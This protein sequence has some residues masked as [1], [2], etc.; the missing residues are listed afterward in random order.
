MLESVLGVRLLL[1]TGNPVPTP[2]PSLIEPL[3]TVEVRNDTESGDGF[4]MT[5]A[6]TKD[7]F[8]RYDVVD[9]LSPGTRV[10]IGAVIGVVPEPLIDGVV[11]RHD[12][13]PSDRPGETTLTVT[14]RTVTSLLGLEE[15][16]TSFANQPDYVIVTRTLASYPELGFVPDVTPTTDVPIELQRT[17]QQ[18]E[19]DLA[20]INRLAE[21]NSF[22]FYS[23][24]ITFGVN[25]A[26]WGPV[27]RAGIPQR[28]L[29]RGMGAHGNC[30]QLS[31]SNDS[32]A[33]EGAT[34]TFVE[35][36]TKMR[37][38]IP[39]LPALRLPPLSASPAGARR[40]TVLRDTANTGPLQTALASAAAATR[41]PEAVRGQ[42]TVETARY[43]GVLRARGLVGV[44]GAGL[45]YDGFYY[46]TQV[47][48]T[49][50]RGSY[51]QGFGLSREGTGTLTPAVVP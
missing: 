19:T 46:V 27:V 7:T 3:R 21:A 8:G 51:V 50:S 39:A 45:D 35:P 24:P 12:L 6:L 25:R 20:M 49:I 41:A 36:L 15:R 48:H 10:W 29:T 5:F 34:G 32:L 30:R 33:P 18:R 37:I 47:T 1:W 44:R 9:T 43:G 14:G 17:P 22:V 31:F 26:H 4:Q 28:A 11:E 13:S 16:N 2:S 23:E 42:G 38:P 40:T